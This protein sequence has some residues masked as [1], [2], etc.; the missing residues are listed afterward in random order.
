MIGITP[1]FSEV[2]KMKALT[3]NTEEQQQLSAHGV[4]PF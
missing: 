1:T 4:F 3:I 2:G